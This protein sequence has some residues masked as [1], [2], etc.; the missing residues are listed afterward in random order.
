M[1]T[2]AQESRDAALRRL[3]QLN[4]SLAVTAVVGVGVITDVV[5]N[6]ASGHT[7]KLVASESRTPA[8]SKPSASHVTRHTPKHTAARQSTSGQSVQSSAPSTATT[9]SQSSSDTSTP[10]VSAASSAPTVVAV[11]GGS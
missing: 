4:R 2:R 10:S 5:A 7:R 11:S 6:T 1:R 3:T 8:K 9:P